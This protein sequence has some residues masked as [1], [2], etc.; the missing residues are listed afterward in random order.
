MLKLSYKYGDTMRN[1]LLEQ[2]V[3]LQLKEK[4][5]LRNLDVK[6]FDREKRTYFFVELKKTREEIEKVKFKIK[7]E[8]KLKNEKS[9]ENI[10]AK[11]S[12][13]NSNKW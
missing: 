6:Y 11:L 2:L 1:T 4:M 12:K 3:D 10:W 9:R 13:V 8:R 7:M 5:I